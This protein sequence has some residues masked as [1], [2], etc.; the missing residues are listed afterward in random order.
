[1]SIGQ[2]IVWIIVSGFA[3]TLR[4]G[5]PITLRNKAFFTLSCEVRV[6]NDGPL[7]P[8]GAKGEAP[9]ELLSKSGVAYQSVQLRPSRSEYYPC[10]S[11]TKPL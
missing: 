5:E 4:L 9:T 7:K 11:A 8:R 2:I 1:M 6:T 3:G 10:L